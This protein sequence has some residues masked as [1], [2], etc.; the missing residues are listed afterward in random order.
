MDWDEIMLRSVEELRKFKFT[1]VRLMKA[2]LEL[3]KTIYI[4]R[5]ILH[6]FNVIYLQAATKIQKVYF[7]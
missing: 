2:D 4:F 1:Q 5:F 6:T 3:T 7:D